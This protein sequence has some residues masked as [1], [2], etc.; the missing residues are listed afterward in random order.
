MDDVAEM[1]VVLARIGVPNDVQ[2]L[3]V[4][5][6]PRHG[7]KPNALMSALTAAGWMKVG[8]DMVVVPREPDDEYI[9]RLGLSMHS[10]EH[11]RPGENW[12]VVRSFYRAMISAAP[13]TASQ[14][15]AQGNR[16]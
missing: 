14:T 10:A 9:E 13:P 2:E 11:S 7:V 4:Y 1:L 15:D 12:P 3:L 6:E 8:P 16:L 5:G